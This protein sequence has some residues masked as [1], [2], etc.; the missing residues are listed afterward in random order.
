MIFRLLEVVIQKQARKYLCRVKT[1]E[2]L[3]RK[4]VIIQ[5]LILLVLPNK[6]FSKEH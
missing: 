1:T 3:I 2:L 4:L 6:N 5:T